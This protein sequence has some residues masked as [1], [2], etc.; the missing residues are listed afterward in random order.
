M[1]KRSILLNKLNWAAIYSTFFMYLYTLK[2]VHESAGA[3]EA[4]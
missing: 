2:R 3:F 1:R 4:A